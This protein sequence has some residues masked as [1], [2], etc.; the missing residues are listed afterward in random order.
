[1]GLGL[2]TL[3]ATN[4]KTIIKVNDT[5]GV[6]VAGIVLEAGEK[7]SGTLMK[8]GNKG[9]KGDKANP[10]VVSDVFARVGGRNNS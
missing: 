7:K 10:I 6:R 2:A 3:V 5:P 8:V 9:Y 4:G 1:L